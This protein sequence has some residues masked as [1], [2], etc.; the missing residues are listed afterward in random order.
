MAFLGPGP[1][2]VDSLGKRPSTWKWHLEATPRLS[3]QEPL[4]L[5]SPAATLGERDRAQ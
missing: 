3:E 4:A 1:G 2:A 5:P